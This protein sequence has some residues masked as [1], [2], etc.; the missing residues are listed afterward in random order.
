M[1]SLFRQIILNNPQIQVLNMYEFSGYSNRDHNIGELILESLL[2]SNIDCITDL[3][4]RSNSLWFRL[5][6][7]S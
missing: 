4:L 6:H 5:H 1:V 2:S 7:R 3:N